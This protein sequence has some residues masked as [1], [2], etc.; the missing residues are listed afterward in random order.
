VLAAQL[1]AIASKRN[2]ATL[3]RDYCKVA[4]PALLMRLPLTADSRSS[5]LRRA[6]LASRGKQDPPGTTTPS[7]LVGNCGTAGR[8]DCL[9]PLSSRP[10]SRM[11][12][13]GKDR[14]PDGEGLL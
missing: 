10:M 12:R 8:A 1:L 11:P 4:I 6:T 9:P 5:N 13:K 3:S 7:L 14:A 2:S